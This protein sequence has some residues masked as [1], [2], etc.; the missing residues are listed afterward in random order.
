[1]P[2]LCRHIHFNTSIDNR[3]HLET[4]SNQIFNG[5]YFQSEATGYFYQLRQTGHSAVFID[6]FDQCSGR[7]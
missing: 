4:I 1:M 7:I 5:D 2:K 6:N 3:L